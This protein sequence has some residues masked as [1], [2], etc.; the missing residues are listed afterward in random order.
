M[1]R[2]PAPFGAPTC[3]PRPQRSTAQPARAE[4]Y[5]L[6][7]GIAK[8]H[9]GGYGLGIIYAKTMFGAAEGGTASGHGGKG[10]AAA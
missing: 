2:R 3:A 6:T 4:T 7:T 8:R 9:G 10:T 5:D 1:H